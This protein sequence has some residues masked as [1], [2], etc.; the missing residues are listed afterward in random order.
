MQ[1]RKKRFENLVSTTHDRARNIKVYPSDCPHDTIKR[2]ASFPD[3]PGTEWRCDICK[4]RFY[5]ATKIVKTIP[6]AQRSG[7]AHNI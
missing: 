5:P 4:L 7:D 3:E 2:D 1:G 6:L